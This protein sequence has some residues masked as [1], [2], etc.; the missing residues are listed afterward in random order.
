MSGREAC[1][2]SKGRFSAIRRPLPDQRDRRPAS[3]L[4]QGTTRLPRQGFAPIFDLQVLADD[5]A[6]ISGSNGLLAART[7]NEQ[8]ASAVCSLSQQQ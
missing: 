4:A 5:F 8:S 2:E 7:T 1:T 3:F 6:I